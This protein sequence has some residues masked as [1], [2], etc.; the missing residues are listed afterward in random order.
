[1]AEGG[2]ASAPRQLIAQLQQEKAALAQSNHELAQE[3]VGLKKVGV[4]EPARARPAPPHRQP[5]PLP[6]A[7]RN[8][9]AL[10]RAWRAGTWLL[11][12]CSARW[13]S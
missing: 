1:M 9:S 10:R 13:R 2:A 7:L 12:H 5:P 4:A 8:L 11:A 3:N 6:A